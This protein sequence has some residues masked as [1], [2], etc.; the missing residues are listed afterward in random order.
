MSKTSDGRTIVCGTHSKENCQ[1]CG[2]SVHAQTAPQDGYAIADHPNFHARWE[3][4]Q[5]SLLPVLSLAH[6]RPWVSVNTAYHDAL[7]NVVKKINTLYTAK[8]GD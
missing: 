3:E 7:E 6:Q 4:L 2:M 5:K 8:L 1:A